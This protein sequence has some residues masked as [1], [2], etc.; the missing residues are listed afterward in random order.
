[1]LSSTDYHR[2]DSVGYAYGIHHDTAH[3]RVHVAICRTRRT[4]ITSGAANPVQQLK[5][6]A[7]DGR[8]QVVVR[9]GI[10]LEKQA[11]LEWRAFYRS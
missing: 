3:L 8:H 2:G 4:E 6:Q 5:R 10:P 11:S 7:A 9:A 1:M